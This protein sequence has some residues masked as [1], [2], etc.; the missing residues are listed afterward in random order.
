MKKSEPQIVIMCEDIEQLKRYLEAIEFVEHIEK[1][2][3]D[4]TKF[5][6]G[7]KVMCKICDKT[8]DEIFDES[9]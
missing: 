3:K 9:E 4:E 1:H 8:I 6:K 7:S 2:L 5:P